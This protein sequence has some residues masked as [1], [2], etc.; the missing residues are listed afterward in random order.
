M[1]TSGTSEGATTRGVATAPNRTLT[2]YSDESEQIHRTQRQKLG[3]EGGSGAYWVWALYD[4]ERG[5]V[6]EPP[7]KPRRLIR[8]PPH[9]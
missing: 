5:R 7:P 2:T 1:D 4:L 6:P 9:R 3:Q 8:K